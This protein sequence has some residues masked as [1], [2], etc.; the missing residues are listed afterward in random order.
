MG[1]GRVKGLLRDHIVEGGVT[2]TGHPVEPATVITVALHTADEVGDVGLLLGVVELD[3]E[4][5]AGVDIL[6]V[7]T[8]LAEALVERSHLG[9]GEVEFPLDDGFGGF[10]VG[11]F[12]FG[13]FHRPSLYSPNAFC[14]RLFITFY[15][16][17]LGR[18]D[19]V[20][21]TPTDGGNRFANYV[22]PS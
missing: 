5:D 21:A 4:A 11:E 7:A 22:A 18:V 14:Q 17:G 19:G 2:A 12:G 15:L 8:G 9:L 1:L 16:S 13:V 3:A 6:V 20:V 10:D